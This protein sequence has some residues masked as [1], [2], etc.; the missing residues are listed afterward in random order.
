MRTISSLIIAFLTK[1]CCAST[2][3]QESEARRKEVQQSQLREERERRSKLEK[4]AR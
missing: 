2:L 1:N 4:M 3:L